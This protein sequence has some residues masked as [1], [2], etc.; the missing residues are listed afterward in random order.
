VDI[1][2]Q[3]V[4]SPERIQAGLAQLK[5]RVEQEREEVER[6]KEK[7]RLTLATVEDIRIATVAVD[8]CLKKATS[9]EEKADDAQKEEEKTR[10][11]K[12]TIDNH[13]YR[14]LELRQREQEALREVKFAEERN[15][16]LTM[17]RTTQVKHAKDVLKGISREL[18]NRER[19][20]SEDIRKASRLRAEVATLKAQLERGRVQHESEQ[21]ARNSEFGSV[22]AAFEAYTA[23]LLSGIASVED[24]CQVSSV[25]Q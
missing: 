7:E 22:V 24:A 5:K 19:H 16:R 15:N 20:A 11:R 23:N 14:V 18:E 9:V 4:S 8:D 2:S 17:Q 1:R 6:L 13:Q 10:S 25:S 12:T 3:L 21:A